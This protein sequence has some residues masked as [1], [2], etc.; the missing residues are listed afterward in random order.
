MAIEKTDIKLMEPK[1][2][3][4]TLSGGGVIT[5]TEILDGAVNNLFD[6]ISRMDRTQ[7]RVSLRKAFMK[8]DTAT[9]DDY[10]GAHVILS[11]PQTDAGVVV[12]LANTKD[13]FDQRSEA[14][15]SIGSPYNLSGALVNHI[16]SA[17]ELALE[18][19]Q[20][21]SFS[22][23]LSSLIYPLVAGSFVSNGGN[24]F[25]VTLLEQN[26]ATIKGGA[27][28]ASLVDGDVLTS[29][30]SS[31]TIA[32]NPKALN[33]VYSTLNCSLYVSALAGAS[34]LQVELEDRSSMYAGL[35]AGQQISNGANSLGILSVSQHAYAGHIAL[36]GLV[37][38][39]FVV[40]DAVFVA[41]VEGEW[42]VVRAVSTEQY[43]HIVPTASHWSSLSGMFVG[44]E[45]RIGTTLVQ[46]TAIS[47]NSQDY[48]VTVTVA[49]TLAADVGTT[50]VISS[51]SLLSTEDLQ[52]ECTLSVLDADI[53]PGV[54][55]TAVLN[56]HLV[57]ITSVG[58]SVGLVRDFTFSEPI[59]KDIQQGDFMQELPSASPTF[60]Y[61]G[62]TT[63]ASDAAASATTITLTDTKKHLFPDGSRQLDSELVGISPGAIPVDNLVNIVEVSRV[64]VI[65]TTG[66]EAL[67]DPLASDTVYP[68]TGSSFQ[69]IELRDQNNVQVNPA[70]YTVDLVA[71][72]I[73]TEAGI[74]MSP[75]TQPIVAHKRHEDMRL[76]TGVDHSTK[77]V[78]LGRPLSQAFT[79]ASSY[80]SSAVVFGDVLSSYEN[81]FDQ[82]TWT[83]VWQDTVI[84]TNAGATYN[85]VAFPIQVTNA[86]AV[87][88]RWAM[89]F[90]SD[91]SFNIIGEHV[92]Q[93]GTGVTNAAGG[94]FTEPTNP[95]TGL[96]YFRLPQEGWGSGWSVGNALR[97]NT[98]GCSKPLWFVRV[99]QQGDDTAALTDAFTVQIRG[100]VN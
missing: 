55:D 23:T 82:V 95:D 21:V 5:G 51:N 25:E 70:L 68:L 30:T 67:T 77:V 78:T 40:G 26:V 98:V 91:T 38:A 10:F 11:E 72:Q 46:A 100:D 7:G 31:W 35:A 9:V 76:V 84:G 80:V 19:Q 47:T 74:D 60:E 94:T 44:Q 66:E 58:T 90:T 3:D 27:A 50:T 17:S 75:Y 69:Q 49:P 86:G 12:L 41:G 13:D 92:G 54:G 59:R 52:V 56:G 42:D 65:H 39:N 33:G 63:L 34:S 16:W 71:G 45:I 97:F 99:T 43:I 1:K 73:T 64:I 8:V 6:D 14:E 57:D 96:P 93:I 20:T 87:T 62:V 53:S 15:L 36:D 89:E 83:D 22:T 81:L 32:G 37:G 61:S 28:V 48:Y 85:D 2:L 4:D 24:N 88:E 18:G 79:A 29:G